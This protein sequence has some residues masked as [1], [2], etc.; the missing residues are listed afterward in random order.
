MKSDIILSNEQWRLRIGDPTVIGWIITIAYFLTFI[1]CLWAGI[2]ARKR[3][4]QNDTPENKGLLIGIAILLLLLGINKQ[5]DLQT[6]LAIIGR[7]L[8]EAQGW[9]NIRRFI[10]MVFIVVVTLMVLFSLAIWFRWMKRRWRRYGLHFVGT[11]LILLFVVI[12]ASSIEHVTFRH[13][14]GH[15]SV[16]YMLLSILELVGILIIGLGSVLCLHRINVRK[17]RDF[18]F[19]WE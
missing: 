19:D 10:Q 12:R 11:V 1:L 14:A 5:L 13:S 9:Y 4:T 18:K 8:A 3:E 7:K 2:S 17:N 6:L 16:L 15:S